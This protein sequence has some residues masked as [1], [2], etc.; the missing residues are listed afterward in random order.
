MSDREK[1]EQTKEF[2][3]DILVEVEQFKATVHR[4][5]GKPT[6]EDIW[7]DSMDDDF[8]HITCHIDESLRSKIS[9][10]EFVEL[11]KLLPKDRVSGRLTEDNK[12]ELVNKNG[13]TY[14]VPMNDREKI[15]S[16]RKWEQAFRVYAAIYSQANLHRSPEIWQY[17]HVINMTASAFIWENVASY[18]FTFR[19]LMSAYP[20]CSWAKT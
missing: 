18:D 8:F 17:I 5:K 4:L 3:R 1:T 10:G 9:R 11:E 14:F 20:H 15:N 19:Q 16:V 13:L 12:M 2:V 6:G 7:L